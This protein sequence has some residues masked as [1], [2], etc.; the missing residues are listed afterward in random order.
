MDSTYSD[1]DSLPKKRDPYVTGLSA[2]C[3]LPKNEG[4]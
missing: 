1:G 2:L 3:S 4:G